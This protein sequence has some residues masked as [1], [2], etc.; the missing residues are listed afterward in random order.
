MNVGSWNFRGDYSLDVSL[1][2]CTDGSLFAELALTVAV[3]HN[4][5]LAAA[6]ALV[7]QSGSSL[8]NC[9]TYLRMAFS[10][11]KVLR[12]F[13]DCCFN[14]SSRLAFRSSFSKE[15]AQWL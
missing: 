1:I 11:D 12:S 4:L 9:L 10:G 3:D 8:A 2:S 15:I 7:F 14:Q 13:H 5:A 6:D